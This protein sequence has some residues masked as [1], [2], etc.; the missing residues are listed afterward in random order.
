M[1]ELSIASSVVEICAEQAHGARVRRVTLEIGQLS[2]VMP[3]AIRFCFDVCAK[4][5][6]VEGATLDIV[7]I[8]GEARCLTCGATLAVDVP[9]G[10][11]A[12]GSESLELISGQQLKIRQMEVV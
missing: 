8:P 6:A 10:Q 5:T 1:H 7:V 9:F 11:C 3:E 4:D 2:A 12:C